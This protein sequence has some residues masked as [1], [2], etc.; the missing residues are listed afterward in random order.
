MSRVWE[1]FNFE[2]SGGKKGGRMER[3]ESLATLLSNP[4][5]EIEHIQDLVT[6]IME[7]GDDKKKLNY[8]FE[9]SNEH[10]AREIDHPLNQA[11]CMGNALVVKYFLDNL[12]N[13]KMELV[14]PKQAGPTQQYSDV[15]SVVAQTIK[16]ELNPKVKPRD[17]KKLLGL[18]E[19]LE[20]LLSNQQVVDATFNIPGSGFGAVF[21]GMLGK[22]EDLFNTQDALGLQLLSTMRRVTTRNQPQL[23]TD[24]QDSMRT[25]LD[26][27]PSTLKTPRYWLNHLYEKIADRDLNKLNPEFLRI[28]MQV[29]YRTSMMDAVFFNLMKDHI[30]NKNSMA[31]VSTLLMI[32]LLEGVICCQTRNGGDQS[33]PYLL[34]QSGVMLYLLDYCKRHYIEDSTAWQDHLPIIHYLISTLKAEELL[35]RI[36]TG[37][38]YV[39]L[40][41]ALKTWALMSKSLEKEPFTSFS[42]LLDKVEAEVE[43]SDI[44][45]PEN[46]IPLVAEEH[47]K[48][49]CNPYQTLNRTLKGA[50]F[51][52]DQL[53]KSKTLQG[54]VM[55]GL[56]HQ[57]QGSP[58]LRAKLP[59][60]TGEACS[61]ATMQSKAQGARALAA[62]ITAAPSPDKNAVEM[63]SSGSSRKNSQGKKSAPAA[64]SSLESSDY[65]SL[66][67]VRAQTADRNL[68]YGLPE[69]IQQQDQAAQV[70]ASLVDLC[71]GTK[72]K[73]PVAPKPVIPAK[74]ALLLPAAKQLS[75]AEL[76][77]VKSQTVRNQQKEIEELKRALAAATAQQP[78]LPTFRSNDLDDLPPPPAFVLD[79]NAEADAPSVGTNSAAMFSVS[80]KQAA[81]SSPFE[82][83]A[84]KG[85][86]NASAGLADDLQTVIRRLR[87]TPSQA[88]ASSV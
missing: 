62:A 87:A 14:S 9:V 40:Y 23:A 64:A 49:A 8:R 71:N 36:A 10:V 21:A 44:Y 17:I 16:D 27:P 28:L 6:A 4:E 51:T 46:V 67:Q 81:A 63:A 86:P 30:L 41:G 19:V 82:G 48:E 73:P 1:S 60:H 38:D 65:T 69:D 33:I 37:F 72:S 45:I 32:S 59:L 47:T 74:S 2:R 75:A 54:Q 13:F 52:R 68:V 25:M 42:V 39:E 88:N 84:K 20:L 7:D 22:T 11:A 57:G 70:T 53:D 50:I 24:L 78:E 5:C 80:A 12:I 18:E 3:R 43:V 83:V 29:G 79:A 77:L 55:R 56:M 26:V 34:N 61:A 35:K 31:E 76:A 66:E 58:Q 85:G 15:L